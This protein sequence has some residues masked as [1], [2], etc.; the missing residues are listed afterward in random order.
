MHIDNKSMTA[1]RLTDS[2]TSMI[3]HQYSNLGQV[4]AFINE[5][6]DTREILKW[7]LKLSLEQTPFHHG[8]NLRGFIHDD[9]FHTGKYKFPYNCTCLLE[10][11]TCF[12][13]DMYYVSGFIIKARIIHLFL[14]VLIMN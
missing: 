1:N 6:T 13:K 14:F 12:M 10:N 7:T 9:V 4:N 5:Y 2:N 11:C 3:C 8:E